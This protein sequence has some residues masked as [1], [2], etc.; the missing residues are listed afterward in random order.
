MTLRLSD[1]TISAIAQLV[2]VGILTG[3][4][5]ID[6]LRTLRLETDGEFLNP[7]ESFI[8]NFQKGI[9]DLLSKSETTD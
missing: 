9:S 2:Q 8:E 7:T 3:T 5:I 1:K 4:D 6:N